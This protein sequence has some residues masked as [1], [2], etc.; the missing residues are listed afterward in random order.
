MAF[1]APAWLWTATT[2]NFWRSLMRLYPSAAITAP[3]SWRKAIGLMPTLAAAVISGLLGKH[4]IHSTP[5]CLR[6]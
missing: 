6:I 3:R 1:S 2:P 4:D 5:S